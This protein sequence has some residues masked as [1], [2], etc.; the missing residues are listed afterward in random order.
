MRVRNNP[1]IK[2][3]I[4]MSERVRSLI[5][6]SESCKVH[7]LTTT[8]HWLAVDFSLV[9]DIY[10]TADLLLTTVKNCILKWMMLWRCY[11]RWFWGFF[12]FIYLPYFFELNPLLLLQF[13]GTVW[14]RALLQI[15]IGWLVCIFLYGVLYKHLYCT[16]S[17]FMF[18]YVY[19]KICTSIAQ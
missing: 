12:W 3:Y 10:Q 4:Y 1:E 8:P 17:L 2:N 13:A 14:G 7:N 18:V 5:R 15:W 19:W 6:R 11:G 16:L 9:L